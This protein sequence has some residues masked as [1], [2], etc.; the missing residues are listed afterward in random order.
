MDEQGLRTALAEVTKQQVAAG[1]SVG[2]IGAQGCG[3]SLRHS[4]GRRQLDAACVV[5]M[6]FAA[7][8]ASL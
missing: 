6:H 8:G 4:L 7:P 5:R 1:I 3:I 2:S